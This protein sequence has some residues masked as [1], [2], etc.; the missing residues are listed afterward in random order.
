M[1]LQGIFRYPKKAN[2][3][4]CSLRSVNRKQI[5]SEFWGDH[6]WK[7]NSLEAKIVFDEFIDF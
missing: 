5:S 1:L 3:Q 7:F 2:P 4:K 6:A